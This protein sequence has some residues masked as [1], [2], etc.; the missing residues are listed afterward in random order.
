[1]TSRQLLQIA[2]DR[3]PAG[4]RRQLA[5]DRY[6][7]GAFKVVRALDGRGVPPRGHRP[8]GR[9]AGRDRRR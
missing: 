6:G 1:V 4:Y 3:L 7:V 8:P 5:R 2:G 9:Y